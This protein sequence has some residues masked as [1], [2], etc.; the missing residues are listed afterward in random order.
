MN[1]RR[2]LDARVA[3]TGHL[4][5]AMFETQS[6]AVG[7]KA[8]STTTMWRT[9]KA[10]RYRPSQ[11]GAY[12]FWKYRLLVEELKPLTGGWAILQWNSRNVHESAIDE[13]RLVLLKPSPCHPPLA[14]TSLLRRCMDDSCAE[15]T[16]NPKTSTP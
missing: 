11:S 7:E 8:L 13:G 3:K 4:S 15:H 1:R 5:G 16:A 14:E 6:P 12:A 2:S 9:R 10:E